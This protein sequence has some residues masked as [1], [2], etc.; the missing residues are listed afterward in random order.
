[1][2]FR[3][4]TKTTLFALFILAFCVSGFTQSTKALANKVVKSTVSIKM[5]N[6][7]LGTYI[8]GSAFSVG[9]GKFITN[10]HVISLGKEGF[11]QK[12]A[13]DSTKIPIKR[14]VSF[15]IDHDL[16]I[17]E[18]DTT[19]IPPLE[20]AEASLE[21][22]DKIYVCGNPLGLTGT[23]SDG[24]ISANRTLEEKEVIQVT[25]PISHGSSGGPVVNESGKVIGVIFSTIQQG[26][27][28]NFV[29]PS[30]Y[31]RKLLASENFSYD[32]PWYNKS[33]TGER[34][35]SIFSTGFDSKRELSYLKLKLSKEKNAIMSIDKASPRRYIF[36]RAEIL[37]YKPDFKIAAR[38]KPAKENEACLYWGNL[39]MPD[40]NSVYYSI[41][42]YYYGFCILTNSVWVELIDKGEGIVKQQP[43]ALNLKNSTF[44]EFCIEKRRD[45]IYFF[46]DSIEIYRELYLRNPGNGIGLGGHGPL[47]IEIDKIEIFQDQDSKANAIEFD[48][49]RKEILYP[50]EEETPLINNETP[51]IGLNNKEAYFTR[52]TYSKKGMESAIYSLKSSENK[53]K[54]NAFLSD[55]KGNYIFGVSP[56]SNIFYVER[57]V[58]DQEVRTNHGLYVYNK[59]TGIKNDFPK[60]DEFYKISSY[61]TYHLSSD[62]NYLISSLY[63]FD[64]F[65]E[66]DLYVSKRKKD[67]SFDAPQ[68]LGSIINTELGEQ[69][70]CMTP[71]NKFLFFT[72]N[73]HPGYGKN[74]IFMTKRLDSTWARWSAPVNLGPEIN[75]SD[76][77]SNPTI[78]SGTG[79]LYFKR[80]AKEKSAFYKVKLPK[81]LVNGFSVYEFKLSG[82]SAYGSLSVE[83]ADAKKPKNIVATSQVES[84]GFF[85]AF[86]NGKVYKVT[87]KAGNKV[88]YE[89]EIDISQVNSYTTASVELK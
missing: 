26:Q 42:H 89:K 8:Q 59:L 60:I 23:F 3:N 2:K 46:A 22:G 35:K 80:Q 43:I 55:A 57:N 19:T 67:G 9:K 69:T 71:D 7:F 39:S 16:A 6:P 20:I 37:S 53:V 54:K 28:L 24:I 13:T 11:I 76:D 82:T 14:I 73:G 31:L 62:G 1:M 47:E 12:S 81:S 27:N 45:S 75:S 49:I 10:Y 5:I 56:S 63:R 77:E 33:F 78:N 4:N 52:Y 79:E 25:A 50:V 74:D 21:V 44:R 38:F 51:L 72:S 68:N 86:E 61:S 29:I 88:L 41:Q 18:I 84:A 65:G 40:Q 66:E 83:I 30:K 34:M 32:L 36:D 58:S 85:W 87:V 17:V 48:S 15:D 64:S 70:T